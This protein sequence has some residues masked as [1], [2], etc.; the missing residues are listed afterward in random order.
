MPLL[1]DTLE[2]RNQRR[3]RENKNPEVS[4]IIIRN[5]FGPLTS[6]GRFLI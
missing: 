1:C 3:E 2:R 6:F 4:N 5:N